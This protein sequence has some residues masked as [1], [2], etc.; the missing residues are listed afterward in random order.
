MTLFILQSIYKLNRNSGKI[1]T[2]PNGA[3]SIEMFFIISLILRI[4]NAF[5]A[6]VRNITTNAEIITA[7]NDIISY[8]ED[9]ETEQSAL[10]DARLD[11]SILE[12]KNK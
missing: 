5:M 10:E 6:A 2:A 1:I 8:F 11:T 3:D 12:T 9:T 7:C 4:E